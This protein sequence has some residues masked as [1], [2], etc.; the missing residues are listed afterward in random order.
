MRM[1]FNPSQCAWFG[2]ALATLAFAP[3]TKQTITVNHFSTNSP[4][5]VNVFLAYAPAQGETKSLTQLCWGGDRGLFS[6]K[7]RLTSLTA[8]DVAGAAVPIHPLL[9]DANLAAWRETVGDA[10]QIG[11]TMALSVAL[12]VDTES[13]LTTITKLDGTLELKLGKSVIRITPE[14]RQKMQTAQSSA[15]ESK[16]F[17]LIEVGDQPRLNLQFSYS[18]EKKGILPNIFFVNATG[19]PIYSSKLSLDGLGMVKISSADPMPPDTKIRVGT[20]MD[21]KNLIPNAIQL[22]Q[23]KELL[24]VALSKHGLRLNE[25]SSNTTTVFT[26][27]L[28]R[29]ASTTLLPEVELDFAGKR[30][31]GQGVAPSA[32]PNPG[33]SV[34]TTWIFDIPAEYADKRPDILVLLPGDEG[35]RPIQFQFHNPFALQTKPL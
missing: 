29:A 28:N 8:V 6:R 15:L 9:G 17:K 4:S 32:Q 3:V 25:F 1:R 35:P 33:T 27:E 12:V 5:G 16:G 26:V 18:N 13:A 22:L 30:I 10:T 20:G 2:V 23:S 19:K 34:T 24:A 21:K 7:F 31:K 11:E 14:S